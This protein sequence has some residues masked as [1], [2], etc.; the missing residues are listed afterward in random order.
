M[1]RGQQENIAFWCL[2]SFHF[3]SH[4]IEQV[5]SSSVVD[6]CWVM[7]NYSNI[8][9]D[10]NKKHKITTK[11]TYLF[12]SEGIQRTKGWILEISQFDTK[13]SILDLICFFIHLCFYFQKYESPRIPTCPSTFLMM[14]V[15]YLQKGHLGDAKTDNWL[16]ILF[17]SFI[18][19]SH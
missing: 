16:L 14:T 9:K 8:L 2:G 18:S 17:S 5:S 10:N 7:M 19:S 12:F 1:K 3:S 15:L 13:A 4:G 6:L 11:D